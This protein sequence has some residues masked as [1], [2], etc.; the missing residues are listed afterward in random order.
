[1]DVTMRDTSRMVLCME[2][3]SFIRDSCVFGEI[4]SGCFREGC[5]GFLKNRDEVRF[6]VTTGFQS[7]R[8]LSDYILVIINIGILIPITMDISKN[9]AFEHSRRM[10]RSWRDVEEQVCWFLIR[11]C[12]NMPILDLK[13]QIEKISF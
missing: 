3:E 5:E 12:N 10:G 4:E 1:M 13:S 11:F 7:R 6:C 8:K 9:D 2:E